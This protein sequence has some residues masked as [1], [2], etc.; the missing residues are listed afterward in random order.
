MNT[1]PKEPPQE[2]AIA[3]PSVQAAVPQESAATATIDGAPAAPREIAAAPT[4]ISPAE[5]GARLATLFPA[6]FVAPGAPGPFKPIKLRIHTDIQARAPGEFSKRVLGIFFSRYTTTH[7]YLK[8]LAAPGA[9]RFDLDG[10][11]AGE[12]AEEHRNAAVEEIARRQAIAAERRAMQPPRRAP[13]LP[14]PRDQPPQPGAPTRDAAAEPRA[15]PQRPPH[16]QRAQR[17]QPD[18]REP[19][20]DT[21]P[22][23]G[24]PQQQRLAPHAQRPPRRD[25]MPRMHTAAPAQEQ[26][27]TP[28][29]ADPA[30]R[31]RALLLRS[32]EAST[33]SKANFCALKRISEAELDAALTQARAERR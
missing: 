1:E 16:E 20:H 7:A 5:C 32:F 9:Q 8:A 30:Q 17:Q 29:A 31:E 2:A 18:G 11:P 15:R 12:I 4:G 24:A 6:L 22:P 27:P 19:R 13:P 10:A 14:P 33:I 25:D 3:E 21:R 23:R 26:A 28:L